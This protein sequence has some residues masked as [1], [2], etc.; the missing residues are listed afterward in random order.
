MPFVSVAAALLAL[1]VSPHFA[2]PLRGRVGRKG[3]VEIAELAAEVGDDVRFSASSRWA[4]AV[5]TTSRHRSTKE[6]GSLPGWGWV[7]IAVGI[8]VV[9]GALLA[10]QALA[11]RRTDRLKGQFGPEYDRTIEAAASRRSAEAEL[12]AR[13]ERHE[14]LQIRPLSSATRDRYLEAWHGIQA[15]FVDDP[16][17]AVLTADSLIQSV[18][19]ERG[20]PV[21]DFEQR[22]A[23]ISVDHPDV[24]ENYREGHRLAEATARRPNG[25]ATEDLRQAM[26]HYRALFDDLLDVDTDEEV[27]REP[28][29]G[30]SRKVLRAGTR[31]DVD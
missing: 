1:A 14:G 5:G 9:L 24:V 13:E 6:V 15:L 11:K 25:S 16:S 30:G 27:A 19:V 22:A 20:Y 3:T 18:M 21:T 26:R 8:V 29:A 10:W 4:P 17:T 23:D 2:S 31:E 7:L 12:A 28:A